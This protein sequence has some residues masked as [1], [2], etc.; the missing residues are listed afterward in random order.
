MYRLHTTCRACNYAFHGSGGNRSRDEK[1]IEVFDLGTQ[2]LANDFRKDGEPRAGHVPLK[3]LLCPKCSLGQLSV[4]VDPAVLYANYSYVTSPSA[5]M[6]K[7]FNRL[8]LDIAAE[9][10]GK[11]V[12]EIGSNDGRL[13]R[14]LQSEGYSVLGVD[15][16]ENLANLACTNDVPTQIGF[17]G[18]ALSRD[19]PQFDI[20]IARHVFCHV[21]DWHDFVRGLEAV[22]HKDTLI[23]IEVPYAVDMLKNCEFDTV[24]HEHTSYLTLKS[25]MALLKPTT[26]QL[27]RVIRYPIHGG[28][29]LL[30][31]R[32]KDSDRQP[33]SQTFLNEENI[34]VEDW[35]A[36]AVEARAQIDRL[37]VNVTALVA[38]GKRVA[39]LGASAKSTVWINACG[40]SRKEIAFISDTTPQKQYTFSPGSN[41]PICDEGAILRELPDYLICFCWNFWGPEMREKFKLYFEKGGQFILP[42][43]SIRVVSKDAET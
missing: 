34:T 8:I 4:V 35:K 7:H 41:I 6:Q 12:L 16:A 31:L 5:T 43:P 28:A 22:S 2:P 42:V 39:G 1:L 11:T 33:S 19:L 17:F 9:T 18:E 21:D 23:C 27:H 24:Y 36:F 37:R 38:Q 40:F 13:L 32:R 3:V 30:M 15:P 14:V 20:V 25:V 26:L 10:G 29:I